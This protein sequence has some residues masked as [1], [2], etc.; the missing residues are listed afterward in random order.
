MKKY[1]HFALFV[2]LFLILSLRVAIPTHAED[3]DDISAIANTNINTKISPDRRVIMNQEKINVMRE[4]A[5]AKMDALKASIKSEKDIT[6]AKIKEARITSREKVLT[7]F[8]EVVKNITN[9]EVR[10]NAQ[11][12]ALDAKSVDTTSAKASI[13]TVDTNL[14]AIN[15]KIAE[16][17]TLLAKSTS[18]ITAD[19]KTTLKTLASDIQTLVKATKQT[20]SDAV[21]SLKASI[22]NKK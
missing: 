10:V 17:N 16:A 11:I 6:K 21:R 9:L 13:A 19:D 2:V 7:R 18:E 22:V 12:S 4:E 15:T 14:T 5:K 1:K 20:L 8:D 3:G